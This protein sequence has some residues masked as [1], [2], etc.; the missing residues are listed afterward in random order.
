MSCLVM[1]CHVVKDSKQKERKRV[2]I[3]S[4]SA[5]PLGPPIENTFQERSEGSFT[6]QWLV[7]VPRTFKVRENLCL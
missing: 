4:I 1:S 7:I 3:G 6:E 2:F 5:T